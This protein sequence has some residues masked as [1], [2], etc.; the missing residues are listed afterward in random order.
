MRV[1]LFFDG[2]NFFCSMS[3]RHPNLE[4]DYDK[5]AHWVVEQVAGSAGDFVG[6]HYYTGHFDLRPSSPHPF[7]RFLTNLEYRRGYSVD[8]EPRV[9]RRSKCSTCGHVRMYRTEKR[10]DTR[11]VADMIHYAAVGA[12]DIAV[13]LSGDQD[14][15]PAVD[16]TERLGR[17]VYVATWGREGL[18]AELR[19]RCFG[20]I[21]LSQGI[22]TFGTGRQPLRQ[23]RPAAGTACQSVSA[24]TPSGP[25]PASPVDLERAVVAEVSNA[26]AKLPYL[27]RWYFEN[28][29]IG[30]S[31]PPQGS[32]E[33]RAAVDAALTGGQVECFAHVD[34]NGR[35]QEALRPRSTR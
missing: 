27:S 31:L 35:K 8:R 26:C 19:R 6:A 10:V 1:A 16:A 3:R 23:A 34:G 30:P 12:Y 29:W 13:L 7:T 4:V 24:A 15:I 17:R 14:L 5:L 28:K 2:K 33:R 18:S 21:D 32:S 25:P 11:L 9:R 22:G 20:G